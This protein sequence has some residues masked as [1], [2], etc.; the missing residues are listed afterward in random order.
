MSFSKSAWLKS[1]DDESE[2]DEILEEAVGL[3]S[4]SICFSSA[5]IRLL[6][7]TMML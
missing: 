5:T 7:A 4:A 6:D 2:D 1:A 3:A